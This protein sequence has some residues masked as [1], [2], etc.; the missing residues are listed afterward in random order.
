MK[1]QDESPDIT[2]S[3]CG[4]TKREVKT[5]IVPRDNDKVAICDECISLCNELIAEQQ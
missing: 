3:F 5:M 4:K 2:C 1:T